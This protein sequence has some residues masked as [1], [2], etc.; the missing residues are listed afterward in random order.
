MTGQDIVAAY[1][2]QPLGFICGVLTVV[3]LVAWYFR[4]TT[5]GDREILLEEKTSQGERVLGNVK[6][7]IRLGDHVAEA[8]ALV[9]T[10]EQH[11]LRP[12]DVAA[13]LRTFYRL[14]SET[15]VK[16]V[17][18][19]QTSGASPAAGPRRGPKLVYQPVGFSV[20]VSGS[21]SQLV[22]FLDRLETGPNPCRFGSMVI[23]TGAGSGE[24]G[25]AADPRLTLYLSLELQ[26]LP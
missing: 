9:A 11:L 18:L 21:F 13:N 6:N 19:Q 5:V 2:R 22:T 10:L 16:L 25:S 15:G 3:F 26:G 24:T 7:S 23:R 20:A 12:T 17:D 1:R 8:T 4:S 14:E